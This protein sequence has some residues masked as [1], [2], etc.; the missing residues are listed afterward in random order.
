MAIDTALALLER[1]GMLARTTDAE[2]RSE[3]L[4]LKDE[5]VDLSG[6]LEGL[7]RK[8]RRDREKLRRM[9]DYVNVRSD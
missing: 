7:E 1:V 9:L 3:C 2:S 8:S 5:Q 4:E 6:L